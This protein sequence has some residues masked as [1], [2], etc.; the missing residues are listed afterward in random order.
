M[1]GAERRYNKINPP[2][3]TVDHILGG[4]SRELGFFGDVDVAA[5]N[6]DQLDQEGAVRKGDS[7]GGIHILRPHWIK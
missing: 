5:V 4:A 3:N 1:R 7:A 2:V 6:D